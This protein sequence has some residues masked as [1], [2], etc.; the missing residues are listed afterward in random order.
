MKRPATSSIHN[1]AWEARLDR[2]LAGKPAVTVPES[3]AL[4]VVEA[5]SCAQFQRRQPRFGFSTGASVGLAAAMAGLVLL[6]VLMA[7]TATL[8]TQPGISPWPMLNQCFYLAEFLL[9]F[10][11]ISF[12]L[13]HG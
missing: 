3:F 11:L 1:A 10:G 12:R 9:L 13:R 8:W 2:V 6:L 5:A 4:R 7:M